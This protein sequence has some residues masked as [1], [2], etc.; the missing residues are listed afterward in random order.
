VRVENQKLKQENMEKR[1]LEEK[2]KI[3]ETRQ[4]KLENGQKEY[5]AIKPDLEKM[6]LEYF[7][8]LGEDFFN[9]VV[10]KKICRN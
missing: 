3:L 7:E 5:E 2:I 4:T 10:S 9:K 8:E 1:Q 6:V